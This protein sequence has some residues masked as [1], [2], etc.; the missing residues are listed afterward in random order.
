MASASSS[1]SVRI[2]LNLTEEEATALMLVISRVGGHPERTPRGHIDDIRVALE[3]HILSISAGD[4]G[5]FFER[6]VGTAASMFFRE[7]SLADF[8]KFVDGR[9]P[10]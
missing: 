4:S 5:S 3:P 7:N 8:V 9:R 6:S 2:T 10:T 1:K